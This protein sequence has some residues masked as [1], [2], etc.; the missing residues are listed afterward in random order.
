[1]DVERI[2]VEHVA[3]QA[4]L[5]L[6]AGVVLWKDALDGLVATGIAAIANEYAC[7]ILDD[8]FDAETVG[9]FAGQ[10]NAIAAGVHLWHHDTDDSLRPKGIHTEGQH[11]R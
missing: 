6:V 3:W 5:G 11:H 7:Q 1:L 10:H 2:T 4:D 9:Q 8:G